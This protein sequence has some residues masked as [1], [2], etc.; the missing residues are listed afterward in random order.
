MAR[1]S[2]HGS[3]VGSRF[4]SGMLF[5]TALLLAG[6]ASSGDVEQIRQ[7]R[8]QAKGKMRAELEQEQRLTSSMTQQSEA[9]QAKA[10]KL[11]QA[12]G[13]KDSSKRPTAMVG[14]AAPLAAASAAASD[15]PT[16][17]VNPCFVF[18][19]P[20]EVANRGVYAA[21]F[22][23][24]TEQ[25]YTPTDGPQKGTPIPTGT[26]VY[27][28]GSDYAIV[29]A[30]GSLPL[31]TLFPQSTPSSDRSTLKTYVLTLTG[32]RVK[33]AAIVISVGTQIQL[34]ASGGTGGAPVPTAGSYP[35]DIYGLFEYTYNSSGLDVDLSQV[36]QVGF[37][38]TIT[39]DPVPPFPAQDGVGMPLCRNCLFTAF[40]NYPDFQTGQAG[41]IFMESYTR[42]NINGDQKRL[43]SPQDVLIAIDG[44]GGPTQGA[45]SVSAGGNLPIPPPPTSGPPAWGFC[46]WVTATSATGETPTAPN[47]QFQVPYNKSVDGHNQPQA[48]VNLNWQPFPGATG[49]NIYRLQVQPANAGLCSPTSAQTQLVGSSSTTTYADAGGG[50]PTQK[51]PPTNNYGYDPLSTYYTA[52]IQ[53]FFAKYT[54]AN[55]FTINVDST[56]W[57]GN[58]MSYKPSWAP[59]TAYTVLRLVGQ[60]GGKYA[61]K[62]ITVY[63]PLFSTNTGNS[64]YPPAPSWLPTPTESP[65]R[66]VFACDGVFTSAQDPE[67]FD[68]GIVK[69][70]EN[71]IVSALNRG[72][73]STVAPTSWANFPLFTSAT[74]APGGSLAGNTYY[75][76]MTALDPSGNEST[77]SFEWQVSVDGSANQSVALQWKP[78]GTDVVSAFKI[79]RGTASGQENTLVTTITNT[80]AVMCATSKTINCYTDTGS[81]G[82]ANTAPPFRY[83]APGTTSNLYAKFLHE[84][85]SYGNPNGIS[86]H[87]LVYGFP[88]DDQ[89]GS[90]TNIGFPTTPTFVPTSVTITLKPWSGNAE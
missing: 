25:A 73:A 6:C 43:V 9:Q 89:G 23:Q 52:A 42:G 39:S 38:F 75:Y 71:P 36:D 46:Y 21:I 78:Q 58:T 57:T 26:Y 47:F 41:Q 87:S 27:F 14:A 3:S 50:T 70:V 4:G 31:V 88:Y 28:T 49:Y 35:N 64:A 68:G 72:I 66:M 22:G 51:N 17:P 10:E 45:S 32:A 7:E 53:A 34:P 20:V 62:V 84:D 82:T 54:P 8:A 79:Y 81:G 12:L 30:S 29:P 65:S 90:S 5:M 77:P 15:C 18:K 63:Q 61:G 76:V 1:V 13:G 11:A 60:A 16:T 67:A 85:S 2:W 80:G 37:P 24:I 19:A 69:D 40:Q 44:L 83:Y 48:T 86:I 56:T 59:K 55:S 74:A 33:G